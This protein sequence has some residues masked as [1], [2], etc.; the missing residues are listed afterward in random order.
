MDNTQLFSFVEVYSDNRLLRKKKLFKP[1][2]Q[3]HGVGIQTTTLSETHRTQRYKGWV[4]L[5]LRE[6]FSV[7]MSGLKVPIVARLK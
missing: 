5:P 3:S 6:P 1:D 2:T 7:T 4:A